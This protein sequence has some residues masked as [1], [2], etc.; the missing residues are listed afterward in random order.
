M[1]E[2]GY[3]L[4]IWTP[5]G[6]RLE[7]REGQPPAVGDPG[8]ARRAR[9]PGGAEGRRVAPSGRLAA[10]R[11]PDGGAV[12]V[13]VT[14]S[15]TQSIVDFVTETIGDHGVPAVFLLMMLE[16]ACIPV[17]SEVIKLFAG[18]LVSQDQMSLVAAILAGTLGNVVGSWIAWG[19]GAC[20][21]RP[22]IERYGQYVHVTPKRMDLADRWF[23]KLR[24]QGR[25]LVAD[26]ADRAHVHLAAGRRRAACRSGGSRSTRS[27]ARCRG[28]RP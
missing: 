15:I 2:A 3:L 16:S 28:A 11:V 4:F 26:A 17:P 25:V 14:L 24:Q 12:A 20:G 8:R 22:F 1:A 23:E 13:L 9:P 19:V 21:G 10:L 5:T 7:E 18:Y 27:S 6:Y